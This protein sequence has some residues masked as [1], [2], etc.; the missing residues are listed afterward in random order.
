MI[1]AL[2]L[3]LCT[4]QLLDKMYIKIFVIMFIQIRE[5]NLSLSLKSA[6]LPV[7]EG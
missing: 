3:M 2:Y 6:Y 4:V 5:L 7:L 1:I